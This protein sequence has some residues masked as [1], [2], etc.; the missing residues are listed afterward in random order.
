[1]NR[2]MR[3]FEGRL[4]SRWRNWYDDDDKYSMDIMYTK[5]ETLIHRLVDELP[6]FT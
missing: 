6:L 5:K 4:T 3:K 2:N 1:M